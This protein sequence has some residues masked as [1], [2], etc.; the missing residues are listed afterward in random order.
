M[1]RWLADK[2]AKR[3]AAESEMSPGVLLSSGYIA[4]G[5]IAGILVAIIAAKWQEL[6]ADMN[7]GERILGE[8]ATN[9][10]LTLLPFGI[11]TVVLLIVGSRK[12]EA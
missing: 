8:A 2:K 9:P 1:M 6:A 11:L 7:V 3:T 12:S 5:T 10:G 4:G